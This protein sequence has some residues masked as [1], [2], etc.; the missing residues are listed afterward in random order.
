MRAAMWMLTGLLAG[1]PLAAAAQPAARP[2][3]DPIA[4]VVRVTGNVRVQ[5][6]TAPPSPAR[7]GLRLRAGDRLN[8]PTGAQA[9]LLYRTGRSQTVTQNIR[10][11]A[12]RGATG[13]GVFQQTIRT[14]NEV[15]STDARA[16]PNRQGM[17]RPIAGSPVPVSPRN[18]VALSATRPGFTWTHVPEATAYLLQLRDVDGGPLVRFPVGTDTTF[19]LPDSAPELVRGRTYEW[20]VARVDGGRAAPPQRFRI[21]A[22]VELDSVNAQLEQLR[23]VG[24]DPQGDGSLLA[25]VVYR[26]AGLLHEAL[27]ALDRVAL[28]GGAGAEFRRMRGEIYA[29]LGMLDR[30][31]ED[32]TAADAE[33]L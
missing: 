16:L 13:A 6:G 21:A 5:V 2:Q 20:S 23:A 18:L 12:P 32:F 14:L 24:L 1:A 8:V 17:I 29:Q 3:S 31:M 7:P 25:A 9:V 27:A 11:Q 28:A 26:Q 30:A 33:D 15:S 22:Q 19:V 10:V 4:V